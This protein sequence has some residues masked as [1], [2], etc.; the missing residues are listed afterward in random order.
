MSISIHTV[1][2]D[3]IVNIGDDNVKFF[4]LAATA[5]AAAVPATPQPAPPSAIA[6]AGG[7][8]GGGGSGRKEGMLEAP[9]P[10]HAK[11]WPS[12]LKEHLVSKHGQVA[13][14][15]MLDCEEEER[16]QRF[17][18]RIVLSY[19]GQTP[20][21]EMAWS[22]DCASKHEAQHV[23]AHLALMHL[24]QC[25]GAAGRDPWSVT[26]AAISPVPIAQA[27]WRLLFT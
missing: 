17:S 4:P 11:S 21:L 24:E 3:N 19:D 8:E 16:Q 27:H 22:G 13:A 5:F 23:A 25:D 15:K 14:E 9:Q 20:V 6:V 2:T 10:P 7:V 1:H 12:A 18:A 26:A